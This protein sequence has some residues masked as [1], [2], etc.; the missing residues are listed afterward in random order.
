MSAA[1]VLNLYCEYI[2]GKVKEKAIK[3]D[4]DGS[5]RRTIQH[6]DPL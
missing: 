1:E 5:D 2:E 4:D 3:S 6:S